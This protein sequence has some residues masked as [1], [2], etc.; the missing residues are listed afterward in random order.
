MNV[1][2]GTRW[3]D[4]DDQVVLYSPEGQ[5]YVELDSSGAELWHVLVSGN[6][7][8][9]AATAHLSDA[10]SM[11]EAIAQEIVQVFI[12]DLESHRILDGR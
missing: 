7:D 12:E 8:V 10:Y 9:S 4:V 5:G 3:V 6:W 2:P 1:K 11:D